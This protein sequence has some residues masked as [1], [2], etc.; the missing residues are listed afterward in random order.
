[1][2]G[3]NRTQITFCIQN[4]NETVYS[5]A[6][7]EHRLLCIFVYLVKIG[8]PDHNGPEMKSNLPFS[9]NFPERKLYLKFVLYITLVET[10]VKPKK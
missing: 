5:S 1:V 10:G 3:D 8:S 4:N 7:N 9:I 6:K 2:L